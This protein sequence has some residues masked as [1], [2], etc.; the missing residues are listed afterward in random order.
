MKRKKIVFVVEFEPPSGAVLR[1]CRR[2]IE[3][4]LFAECGMRSVD[5]PM[6]YLDRHTIKVKAAIREVK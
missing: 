1:D 5:D 4:A 3:C 2:Y 6:H